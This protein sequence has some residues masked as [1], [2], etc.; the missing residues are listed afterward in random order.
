MA[1]L[2][3]DV[4]AQFLGTKVYGVQSLIGAPHGKF[5]VI[6]VT[7]ASDENYA[8]GGIAADLT[9]TGVGKVRWVFF[10]EGS[11]GFKCE[12]DAANK[13]IKMYTHAGAEVT[14]GSTQTNSKS[15]LALVFAS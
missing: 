8:T 6:P 2:D 12:Y 7:F 14:A 5:Y 15:I 10:N 9:V 1:T 13:K 3:K 4:F 11:L